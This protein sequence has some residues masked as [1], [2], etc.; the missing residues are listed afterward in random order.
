M[1]R[2]MRDE[3]GLETKARSYAV[4]RLGSKCS[5]ADQMQ[6]GGWWRIAVTN[7]RSLAHQELVE[8]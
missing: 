8:K 7:V 6:W 1:R 5:G 4:K 2:V 3:A